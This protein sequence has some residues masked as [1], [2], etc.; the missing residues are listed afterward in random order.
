M[1]GEESPPPAPV[2]R[3]IKELEA[4]LPREQDTLSEIKEAKLA[5]D[6]PQPIS[7][8]AEI[9]GYLFDFLFATQDASTSSLVWAVVLL[10]LHPELLAKMREMTLR[11]WHVRW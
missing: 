11:R 10:E 3:F 4:R 5:G 2:S 9:S 6:T 7:I 8:D 1:R